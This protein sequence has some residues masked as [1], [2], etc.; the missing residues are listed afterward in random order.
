MDET[1]LSERYLTVAEANRR[2][3]ASSEDAEEYEDTIMTDD[4]DR[5]LLLGDLSHALA[6]LGN[7]GRAPR[8]LDCCGGAGKAAMLLHELGCETVL[9][10]ISP[11]MIERYRAN[12]DTRGLTAKTYCS[13]IASFF[14]ANDERFDVMVFCSALHHLE[15]PV[16]VLRLAAAALSRPGVLVTMFDPVRQTRWKHALLEPA[17][18]IDRALISPNLLLRR[19]LPV[20]RRTLGRF[21]REPAAA[22]KLDSSNIGALAEFHGEAGFDD[23]KLAHDIQEQCGL[24]LVQHRQYTPRGGPMQT[25]MR[26]LLRAKTTFSL[27]FQKV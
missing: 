27:I 8:A 26:K 11:A 20:L 15:D 4:R 17:R 1:E 12:C 10:D 6:A 21:K 23:V 18:M 7:L 22:I 3:Y 16:L 13:E 2:L 9:V 25:I 19:A 5:R 24:Q 14:Q